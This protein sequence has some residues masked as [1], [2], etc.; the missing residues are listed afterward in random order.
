LRNLFSEKE[1]Q[2]QTEEEREMKNGGIYRKRENE[3]E[4]ETKRERETFERLRES[5]CRL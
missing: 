3:R 1:I 2:R 5:V 4:K